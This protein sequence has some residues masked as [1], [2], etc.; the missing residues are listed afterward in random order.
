[1]A[2]QATDVIV[3]SSV[4]AGQRSACTQVT[5]SNFKSPILSP[6]SIPM[7]YLLIAYLI[8]LYTTNNGIENICEFF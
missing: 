6:Y 4:A 8:L 5:G 2:A 1:M 7:Q 3:A